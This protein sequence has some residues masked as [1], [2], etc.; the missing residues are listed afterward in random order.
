MKPLKWGVVSTAKIGLE[1][2]LPAMASSPDCEIVAIASRDRERAE[3]AARKLG[4]PRSYGR[5]ED[6]FADA[7]VEAVYNPLPNHL[8]VSVSIQAIEAGKHVLCEKP[9]GMTAQ[10]VAP[11]ITAR[12]RAG[13]IVA[14]AFMVRHHP[15]WIRARDLIHDGAIG[16]LRAVQGAFSYFND[17]ADNIRNKTET[18]GGALY[19]IG[20][21]P[22][23]A[24]RYLFGAEPR[25][26]LGLIERDPAFGTDRLTTAVLD[27]EAGQASFVC[28][29]QLVPYQRVQAFG[30]RG[31]IEIEIPFNA[32]PDRPCRI[33]V[34]DGAA[35]DGSSA[36]TESFDSCDQYRLQG[37]AFARCVRDG[38]AVEFPLEDSVGNMNVVDALFK[39][40]A[41]CRWVDIER[42]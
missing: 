14:E 27:F 4:I 20:V 10:E 36:R 40:A 28:S 29:T 17:N 42:S 32:P 8:H 31:R 12:D 2:V 34:D 1:K 16:E 9:L 5:Y 33:F 25:R 7:E 18:G 15:Q 37:E 35:P 39:S 24:A 13:V 30:T 26:A 19:D 23:V 11:L 41:D 22:I 6:L 21:Y 38:V 3:S